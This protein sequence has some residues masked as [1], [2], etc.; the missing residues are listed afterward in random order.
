M[1]LVLYQQHYVMKEVKQ[2]LPLPL[3]NG[4]NSLL[5][6]DKIMNKLLLIYAK[7]YHYWHKH[8]YYKWF[9]YTFLKIFYDIISVHSLEVLF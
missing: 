8:K 5:K 3:Q 7:N 1:L 6:K 2:G 9:Q 4:K